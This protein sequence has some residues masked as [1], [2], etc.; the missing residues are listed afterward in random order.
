MDSRLQA[1]TDDVR[2]SRSPRRS[3]QIIQAITSPVRSLY[4]EQGM[5]SI[6]SQA[7][8]GLRTADFFE[9]SSEDESPQ[10]ETS[11]VN[12]LENADS[13]ERRA[14]TRDQKQMHSESNPS[15]VKPNADGYQRLTTNI[16]HDE[17]VQFAH[18]P[19]T[20]FNGSVG[21]VD[22]LLPTRLHSS[23]PEAPK[24]T[25][26]R[27]PRSSLQVDRRLAVHP[28]KVEQL[29][30]AHA[31][32]HE[33]TLQALLRDEQAHDMSLQSFA[34]VHQNDRASVLSP[35]LRAYDPRSPR[36]VGFAA[37]SNG[38]KVQVVPPPIDT[39]LPKH[40]LPPDMVLTPYPRS[41]RSEQ[42]REN[43]L[44]SPTSASTQPLPLESTLVLSVR[45]SHMYVLPRVS[46]LII[47]ASNDFSA[48]R[49]GNVGEKEHH[50]KAL[51]KD[52]AEFFRQLRTEFRRLTGPARFFS[53][54]SLKRIVVS[55][56]AT[57]AADADYGWL[58]QTPSPRLLARAGLSDT[59]SEERTLQH[60]RKPDLG[61]ARYAYVAW[62][63]RLAAAPTTR[64][65]CSTPDGMPSEAPAQE[66]ERS[67]GLEFVIGWSIMRI[68]LVLA[69]VMLLSV[70]AA[71]VWV[72]LGRHTAPA[73]P[74]SGGYRDAG[75]RA[76]TALLMGICVLLLGLSSVAA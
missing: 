57:R 39:S 5:E 28:E 53:A 7:D 22:E 11:N 13:Q 64:P 27:S 31:I 62:A 75:D 8:F 63:H 72:F 68:A 36:N 17:R 73:S 52:D 67:E 42:K 30:G 56:P 10:G 43:T 23:P 34:P 20:T 50:F 65:S 69:S 32:A 6:Q 76:T 14:Q 47:P 37:A 60:Y 38:K 2:I 49:S 66:V 35:A 12:F 70:V 33:I 61:R 54:R 55:G 1:N 18:S 59:F 21:S 19:G 45:R 15:N 16:G 25:H 9:D 29:L 3:P 71:L 46:T 4:P 41:Q 40:P 24:S 26:H 74:S 51:E 44:Q 48:I 58:H